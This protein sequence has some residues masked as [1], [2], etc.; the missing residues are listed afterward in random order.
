MTRDAIIELARD[1]GQPVDDVLE[2]WGERAAIREFD[3]GQP[4]ATAEVDALADVQAWLGAGRLGPRR[5]GSHMA[6]SKRDAK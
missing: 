6:A 4:R 5:A 2:W 3:G 1:A